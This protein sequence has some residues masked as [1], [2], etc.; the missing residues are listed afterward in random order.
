MSRK[1]QPSTGLEGEKK[2]SRAGEGK[3]RESFPSSGWNHLKVKLKCK[4]WCLRALAGEEWCHLGSH[5][6]GGGALMG[7]GEVFPC[8]SSDIRWWLRLRRGAGS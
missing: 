1:K 2:E 5:G 7:G 3:R 8:C 6:L 4:S